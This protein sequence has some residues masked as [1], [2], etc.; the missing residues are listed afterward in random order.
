[1]VVPVLEVSVDVAVLVLPGV[2]KGSEILEVC[3]Q[4][5]SSAILMTGEMRILH[6]YIYKNYLYELTNILWLELSS[7]SLGLS[8]GLS[9]GWG[10]PR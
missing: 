7:P 1:M 6:I 8:L 2:R 3:Q 4:D 9:L 5:F 10:R